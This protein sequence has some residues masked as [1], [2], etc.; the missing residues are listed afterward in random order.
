[1][2][3]STKKKKKK[4]GEKKKKEITQVIKQQV[5]AVAVAACRGGLRCGSG[6]L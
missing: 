5:F 1:M 4:E 2:G 3:Q 6:E